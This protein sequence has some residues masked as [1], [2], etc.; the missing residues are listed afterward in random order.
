VALAALPV[1]AYQGALTWLSARYAAPWLT[2]HGA[3][4]A[5]LAVDGLLVL[6]VAVVMFDLRKVELADYIPAL[7]IAP[8][9]AV[10]FW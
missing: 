4:D 10:Y 8:P 5:A 3:F 9:L 7:A 1:L 2:A 6:Y